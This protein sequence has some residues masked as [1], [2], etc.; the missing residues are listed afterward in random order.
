MYYY[1]LDETGGVANLAEKI[2]LNRAVLDYLET[3]PEG[4]SKV[5]LILRDSIAALQDKVARK[6]LNLSAT[7]K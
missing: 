1:F 4:I 2:L 3:E 6:I 7:P 5:D